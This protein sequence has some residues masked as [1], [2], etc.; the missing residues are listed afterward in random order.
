[1]QKRKVVTRSGQ[2]MRG[3]YPSTKN[4]RSV[5]FESPLEKDACLLFE[6]SRGVA[7]Y[8]EYQELTCYYDGTKEKKY[9]PDYVVT[10]SSG[11]EWFVEVKPSFEMQKRAIRRR[12]ALIEEHFQRIG[13]KLRV[14]TDTEIRREP[15]FSHL[16][17][18]SYYRPRHPTEITPHML[19]LVQQFTS[20]SYHRA[21]SFFGGEPALRKLIAAG[22]LGCDLN[23]PCLSMS[24]IHAYREAENDSLFF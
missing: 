19:E 10:L 5:P 24:L 6:F 20:A 4:R 13:Q 23:V 3:Y 8:R 15:R 9:Y 7:S 21:A 1:M 16:Q 11:D 17:Q 14:L 2:S 18:L 22:H 12:F